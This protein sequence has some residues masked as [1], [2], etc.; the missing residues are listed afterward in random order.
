MAPTMSQKINGDV[1]A[2]WVDPVIST[3]SSTF[4]REG[5]LE[6]AFLN[7][8]HFFRLGCHDPLRR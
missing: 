4:T 3:T 6:R 8:G 1:Y 7:V 5:N 2:S